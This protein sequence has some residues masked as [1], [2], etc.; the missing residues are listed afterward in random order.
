LPAVA[1]ASRL[2]PL[3][4]HAGVIPK[5]RVLCKLRMGKRPSLEEQVERLEG[6]A[7]WE[8]KVL[9]ERNERKVE[10]SLNELND[11][12]W[13]PVA[14]HILV[15]MLIGMIADHYVILRRSKT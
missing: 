4:R 3:T 1:V 10:K 14:Y 7:V 11:A 9:K 13:E 12:G 5:R 8:Y 2:G 6:L 15:R